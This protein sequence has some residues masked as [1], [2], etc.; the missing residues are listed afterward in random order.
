MS[1]GV[2]R[3][4]RRSVR[5][6]PWFCETIDERPYRGRSL[7][8]ARRDFFP[9]VSGL[10]GPAVQGERERERDRARLRRFSALGTKQPRAEPPKLSPFQSRSNI[11][12][13]ISLVPLSKLSFTRTLEGFLEEKRD[14]ARL[15]RAEEGARGGREDR[16]TI[17]AISSESARGAA[18]RPVRQ[19]PPSGPSLPERDLLVVTGAGFE[20]LLADHFSGMSIPP[21][22]MH[23]T[24]RFRFRCHTGVSIR[25]CIR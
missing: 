10:Q 13:R 14:G 20:I 8:I 6:G 4:T 25:A 18:T 21:C 17:G 16:S 15:L 11:R 22:E 1:A 23:P 2:G 3:K 19:G 24:F 12:T 5:E 9:G 7:A